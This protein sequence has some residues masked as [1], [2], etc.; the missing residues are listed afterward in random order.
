MN[1]PDDV[2]LAFYQKHKDKPYKKCKTQPHRRPVLKKIYLIHIFFPLRFFTTQLRWIHA[3]NVTK[4]FISAMG[5]DCQRN[6]HSISWNWKYHYTT[7]QLHIN[8]YFW[9]PFWLVVRPI[10]KKRVKQTM[11]YPIR[12]NS[13]FHGISPD[14]T[15]SLFSLY[16]IYKN[17]LH[18]RTFYD[19]L[20]IEIKTQFSLTLLRWEFLSEKKYNFRKWHCIYI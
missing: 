20:T 10:S 4:S 12:V 2:Y 15:D 7:V 16:L 6:R 11:W 17:R 9:N 13:I 5:N 14:S 18:I 1:H 8:S 19:I 3:P